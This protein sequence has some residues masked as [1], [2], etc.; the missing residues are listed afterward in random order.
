MPS[1][2]T[3]IRASIEVGICGITVFDPPQKNQASKI[4]SKDLIELVFQH[5]Y[6]KIQFLID[7][8]IAQ[9]Q[10]ASQYLQTFASLKLLR[11]LRKGRDMYY[12]NDALIKILS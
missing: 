2:R 5:P 4:Y 6:C 1:K 8:K 10:T 11:P 7:A 3:R 12:V 9:R